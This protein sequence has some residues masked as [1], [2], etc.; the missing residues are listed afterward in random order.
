MSETSQKFISSYDSSV[1]SVQK[2][3][4]D[5]LLN[6]RSR[7]GFI[8]TR[9]QRDVEVEVKY[10]NLGGKFFSYEDIVPQTTIRG[11]KFNTDF[12]NIFLDL[13]TLYAQL[14]VIS[15]NKSK[16]LAITNDAFIK[17]RSAINAL[18]NQLRLFRFLKSNQ[19][20][21]DG[22]YISF[23]ESTNRTSLNPVAVIDSKSKKL[24][25][26]LSNDN[27]YAIG[28]FNLDR[29]TAEVSHYGGGIVGSSEGNF[30]IDNT[31][32]SNP[33]NF[34]AQSVL[35][36][37]LPSYSLLLSHNSNYR[38]L[39][40]GIQNGHVYES[41]GIVF[42]LKYQFYK[43]VHTNNIRLQPIAD[44]PVR[45]LDIAYK[46]STLSSDWI[47]IPD[48][49]PTNY[50][51]TLDWIE[52]N[53]P[54]I[55]MT[56]LKI[57][58]EQQNYTTNIYHIPADLVS[59]NQLWTQIIDKSFDETVHNLVIDEVI[60]DKIQADPRLITLLNEEYDLNNKLFEQ[61]MSGKKTRIYDFIER[62][63]GSI[64]NAITKSDS[65]FEGKK[66]FSQAPLV[67]IKKL[68]YVCGVRS[69]EVNDYQYQP[70]GAYESQKFDTSSNPLEISIDTNEEH[71]YY[72]DGITG[73]K[74]KNTS[75]EYEVEIGSNT[76]IPIA[77]SNDIIDTSIGTQVS[78]TDEI[79]I[80]NDQTLTA[81]TRFYVP[82]FDSNL[83]P[84]IQIRKNGNRY[85]P[86]VLNST[87]TGASK[88]NYTSSYVTVNGHRYIKIVFNG[89]TFDSRSI[90]TISYMASIDAAVIDINSN[91]DSEVTPE[92]ERFTETDKDN[93]VSLKYFPYVEYSIINN[94]KVWHQ[95][96]TEQVWEFVPALTNYTLG[97]IT[98]DTGTPYT[99]TGNGTFW[100]DAG[101]RGFITG[102]FYELSGASIQIVGDTNIYPISGVLSN[103]GLTL[104]TPIDYG[105][106]P[107][108][109][110][111][112]GM[113]YIIGKTVDIDGTTYGLSNTTYE[114]VKVY[115]ND[116]KSTNMTDYTTLRHNAFIPQDV[117]RVYEYIQ[118]GKHIYFNAPINGTI[119]VVYNHMSEYIKVNALLRN[120]SVVNPTDTPVISD[121]LI[122]IKDSK[123]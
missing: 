112:T 80:I 75:I 39:A 99:I 88:Y 103:S 121:I 10:A 97:R 65:F 92:P 120:H 84:S 86:L 13:Q 95:Q 59:N 19:E 55:Y 113:Q 96:G 68:Q 118:A 29:T 49:D 119:E 47:T 100:E 101:I 30:A 28:R 46:T 9:G 105:F 122:K 41:N 82:A 42:D 15:S 34:W 93:K 11:D 35:I 51:E 83:I 8:V 81:I 24:K 38:K 74:F 5:S 106:L 66:L 111:P 62:A 26:P 20:Y 58:I 44:Y 32:D 79:M 21:Q 117:T 43:T 23:T 64:T 48:F 22:K 31:L 76:R 18:I 40:S 45:V 16:I 6:E 36:D 90:Y 53:G 14:A 37:S 2:K 104:S 123:I 114:P 67:E 108:G 63:K 27:R 89:S 12:E 4:V 85:S 69:I 57:T 110:L 50:D 60:S 33:E 78:V 71:R 94:D 70:F 73:I 109:V 61:G 17:T 115:V 91:F 116:I 77:P 107:S 25:L 102:S 98:F 3:L 52:W 72:T 54:R 56:D 1:P 87:V 7:Q